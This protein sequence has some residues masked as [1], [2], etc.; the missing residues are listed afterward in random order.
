MALYKYLIQVKSKRLILNQKKTGF[1]NSGKCKFLIIKSP[2]LF[3]FYD[4]LIQKEPF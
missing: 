2:K 4:F 3:V 1:F